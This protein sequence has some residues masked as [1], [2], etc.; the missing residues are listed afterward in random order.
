[1]RRA[2]K[3]GDPRARRQERQHHLRRRRPRGRRGRGALR[4]VR[5]RRPG[6]LRPFADPGAGGRLRAVHG[7]TSSRRSR[8]CG[9]SIPSDEKSEMGPL[10]SAEQRAAVASFVPDDAPGRVPGKRPG[11]ARVLVSAD[12]AR[13]CAAADRRRSV[14]RSSARSWPCCRFEDEA[15]AIRMANDTPYGLSGSI[16]TRDV[17]RAFRVARAVET[18]NHL[19]ELELVCALL[20]PIRRLQALR[21]RARARARCP[22]GVHRAQERVRRHRKLIVAP[23]LLTTYDRG[24][25]M[26]GRLEGKVAV[27]TGAASGIGRRE[28]RQVR[29]RRSSRRC[30]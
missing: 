29:A 9:S 4:G 18:G 14:R 28:C 21:D 6:L 17:G 7:A 8:R 26:S 10:I 5:Q 25:T 20:D 1:M 3:A 15:D 12:G 13:A 27:I 24:K 23:V 30:R 22:R 2:G 11:G 19:G 16:W